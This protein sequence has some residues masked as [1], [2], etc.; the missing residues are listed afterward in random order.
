MKY[1][2]DK[3]KKLEKSRFSVFTNDMDHCYY[4]YQ[5]RDDLHELLEGRN[6]L[7]SMRY[8]FVLPLC[9]KHHQE[10]HNDLKR[11]NEWKKVCQEYFESEYPHEAWMKIFM[12]NYR[13]F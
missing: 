4:C 12:K 11:T 9:R 6:R 2:T 3:L 13:D 8:G 10:L 1:K 5:K 7:N